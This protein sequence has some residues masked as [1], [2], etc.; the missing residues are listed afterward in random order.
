MSEEEILRKIE[1]YRGIIGKVLEAF[2][3]ISFPI[4]V[5]VAT[6]TKVEPFNLKAE[7]DKKL[8]EELAKLADI[9][10]RRFYENP[11]RI[12]RINEVSNFLERE[13]PKIFNTN[14]EKF[15]VIKKVEHLG[16]M[17]YPDEEILDSFGRTTYVDIK[18]TTRP[19]TG[20]ARDFY[21]TP[22]TEAKKKIR[23]NAR[24]SLS[25]F[26]ITGDPNMFR[27]IGWKLVDLSKIRVSMKPEFN[28]DNKE[29]YRKETI[30][31]E[32]YICT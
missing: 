25:S 5:E 32:R 9:T 14:R 24:H 22:L 13:F 8:V 17:G 15:E 23:K 26:I 20:S 11:I 12:R 18:G 28:A 10:L 30:V 29:L 31:A 19:E 3:G 7:E 16:G 4:I 2:K 1:E 6:D 27:T 21:F